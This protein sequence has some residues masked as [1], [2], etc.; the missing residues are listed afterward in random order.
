MPFDVVSY[1]PPGVFI[2]EVLT[3]NGINI[4][5]LPFTTTLIGTASRNKRITNEAVQRGETIGE[6]ITPAGSSP[7]TATL[8]SRGDRR[9][10]NTTVTRTVGGIGTTVPPGLLSYLA[11]NIA[12]TAAGPYNLSA[13]N[14]FG[15]DMDGQR[16]I[17]LALYTLPTLVVSSTAFSL[18]AGGTVYS[19]PFRTPKG[20]VTLTLTTTGVTITGS[21]VTVTVV[22]TDGAGAPQT[23]TFTGVANGSATV[24]LSQ[25]I[26]TWSSIATVTF[27]GAV[28]AG[29]IS[30]GILAAG[31]SIQ[32]QQISVGST[33]SNIAT[34]T[35]AEVAAAIN[36]G[37][38]NASTLGFGSA[39]AT[40][41]TDN[42]T[43]IKLT[44]QVTT[45]SSD[46]RVFAAPAQ[47]A[48]NTLYG[49]A[50]LNA[51]TIIQISD[52]AWSSVATWK[53]NYV[54]ASDSVLFPSAAIVQDNL[55]ALANTNIQDIVSAG[56]FAGVGN[57]IQGRDYQL[58]T[59]QID[60]SINTA[61][62]FNAG[63]APASFALTGGGSSAQVTL[64][65]DGQASITFDLVAQ[66]NA[67]LGY[68]TIGAPATASAAAIAANI[69]AM[70]SQQYG[71]RY[72]GV[73]A[74]VSSKV[75][76]TSPSKGSS[77]SI[78]I[79]SPATGSAVSTVFGVTSTTVLGTGSK[80]ASGAVY[81]VTYD[82]TRPTTDYNRP[83]QFFD[84]AS[85]TAQ[86]GLVSASTF[87]Y[88]P[89]AKGVEI[90]FLN[91]A[92]QIFLIQI[93]DVS[94]P[95]TPTRNET[96]TA[97]Q[98]AE[99]LD[100][101]TE[102]IILDQ[103]GTNLA[104]TVD[105]VAHVETQSG[106]TVKHYRRGHFGMVQNT[107]AG[108]VDTPASFV[109]EAVNT[110]QVSASSPGRG[111]YFLWAPAQQSGISRDFQ[112]DDGSTARLQLDST[113][114]AVAGAALRTS[115]LSP[116]DTLVNTTLNG[117]NIDDI[118]NPF[119]QGEINLMASNGV[120][121]PN[122]VGGRLILKDPKTTEAGLGAGA[123]ISFTQDSASYQKDNVTRL[124]TAALDENIVGIV[125]FDLA[126]FLIDI[127]IV[128][129]GVLSNLSSSAVGAIGPYRRDDGTIRPIDIRT[130]IRVS[131]SPT[132]PTKYYFSYWFSLRYPALRL[133]GQYSVDTPF[134]S[135]NSA[136]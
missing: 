71:P 118:T 89:L 50:F 35:R 116:A 63:P 2:Q 99:L 98:A 66:A 33:F 112:L 17:T 62:I 48:T 57:F 40:A 131:Q 1:T 31:V 84:A 5:G 85:A 92:Q 10:G 95:G 11:A 120:T 64:S 55:D 114:V 77:S 6:T 124:I 65:L 18:L 132:D 117:F 68:A 108:N 49:A 45:P 51:A 83:M 101:M 107:P 23:G 88:N 125:P 121:V 115:L 58:T 61:A 41:A 97:L 102:I 53:A 93:N 59:N 8:A 133:F 128:I 37:L 4:A 134:F 3:P 28:T 135:L 36:T 73:A 94:S 60:W 67:P 126:N 29:S 105:L 72:D 81:F 130:D 80:P 91:G 136:A 19:G 109:Y 100:A 27:G 90:A 52:L 103:P 56:S 13:N 75:V 44:S 122:F 82:F 7:H 69:N 79:T 20:A 87:L 129:Q 34:A 38:S 54:F 25:G 47:D 9:I 32:G 15:L 111:R 21:P 119:S 78:T 22:G 76:L 74:A 16:P 86:V 39:Y 104:I 12:G 123:L 106:P 30:L 113:Y 110:L 24:N 96:D 14:A 70:L 43:G 127:K 26:L 46:V 42:T